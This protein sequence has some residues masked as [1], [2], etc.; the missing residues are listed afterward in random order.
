MFHYLPEWQNTG[1]CCRMLGSRAYRMAGAFG[2][3]T[4]RPETVRC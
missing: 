4:L 2:A 1:M 3:L